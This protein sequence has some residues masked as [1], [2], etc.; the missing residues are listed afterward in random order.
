VLGSAQKTTRK[1]RTIKI[2]VK[3]PAKR[4]RAPGMPSLPQLPGYRLI[5]GAFGIVARTVGKAAAFDLFRCDAVDRAVCLCRKVVTRLLAQVR[6]GREHVVQGEDPAP[7]F[8]H[9]PGGT[10]VG[11]RELLAKFVRGARW[12]EQV[13]ELVGI[14]QDGTIMHV[15]VKDLCPT[16]SGT[17][18]LWIMGTPVREGMTYERMLEFLRDANRDHEEVGHMRQLLEVD[19]DGKRFRYLNLFLFDTRGLIVY[20]VGFEYPAWNRLPRDGCLAKLGVLIQ[21]TLLLQA[22]A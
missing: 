4:G 8:V 19:L 6:P 22:S 11:E 18:V 13:Y 17:F 3:K 16:S 9:V 14:E 5:A 15:N 1:P 12:R 7:H 20:S 2:A 21:Q 10:S